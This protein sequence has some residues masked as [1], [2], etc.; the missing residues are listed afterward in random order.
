[1]LNLS[2]WTEPKMVKVQLK[3]NWDTKVWNK[4]NHEPIWSI[5]N[6]N[7]SNNYND[8]IWIKF[9]RL[10]LN[11]EGSIQNQIK[12]KGSRVNHKDSTWTEF[13]RIPSSAE[14]RR[15][16]LK[17]KLKE[18]KLRRTT[19]DLAQIKHKEVQGFKLSRNIKARFKLKSNNVQAK[20]NHKGST[21]T[22]L[23]NILNWAKI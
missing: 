23:K 10:K 3:Q 15:A 4:P 21:R 18:F 12:L 2:W 20:P 9:K 1:M 5:P 11:Y 14:S 7:R 19:R 6:Y 16:Q 13:K 8:L 22:K 17:S